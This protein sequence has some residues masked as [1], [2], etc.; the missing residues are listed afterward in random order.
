[1]T[2]LLIALGAGLGGA[3]RHGLNEGLTKVV[4]DGFPFGIL[5]V[6]V[7]GCLSMG[8]IVGWLAFR[9]EASLELR[10]FFTTGVLGGFTTFSAFALDTARLYERR[11]NLV[12]CPLCCRLGWSLA[13]GIVHRSVEHAG[14]A[15]IER[16][17]VLRNENA[18][19][20]GS[21]AFQRWT[22]R[23]DARLLSPA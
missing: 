10:I 14:V 23:L 18:M 1:M 2:W 11:A 22:P 6:N 16:A 20:L 19:L 15:A 4:G 5:A 12:V 3:L 21:A 13:G 9:G 17:H 8:L 7:L